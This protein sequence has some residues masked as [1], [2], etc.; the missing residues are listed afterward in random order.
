[1]LKYSCLRSLIQES[2]YG[3]GIN[4]PEL[5]AAA[6]VG[7]ERQRSEIET[8]IAELRRQLRRRAEHNGHGALAAEGAAPVQ[9]RVLS[10]AARK[11]IAVAQRKRWAEYRKAEHPVAAKK[12]SGVQKAAAKPMRHMSAAGR[13]RIAEAQRKRWAA[14]RAKKTPQKTVQAAPKVKSAGA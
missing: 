1:M 6:L 11:R 4:D 2:R 10:A 8:K 7:Y 3:L 14:V 12:T 9:R 5:L 13:K